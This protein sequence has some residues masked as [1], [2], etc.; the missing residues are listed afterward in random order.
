MFFIPNVNPK[1]SSH[2]T[3]ILSLLIPPKKLEWK[4]HTHIVKNTCIP[5]NVC[6]VLIMH[7]C[8]CDKIAFP[9]VY[10]SRPSGDISETKRTWEL[11]MGTRVLDMV[12]E[13]NLGLRP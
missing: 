9:N 8:F 5:N 1:K 12:I 13:G 10:P 2:Q 7:A 3:L 11:I 6:V 4:E